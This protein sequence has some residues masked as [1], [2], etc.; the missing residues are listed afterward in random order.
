MR[1]VAASEDVAGDIKQHAA[2][3]TAATTKAAK[4]NANTHGRS[5]SQRNRSRDI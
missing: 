4:S 2:G 3:I 1:I 5:A